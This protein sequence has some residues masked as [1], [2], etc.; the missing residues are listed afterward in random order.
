MKR[1]LYFCLITF[2]LIFLFGYDTKDIVLTDVETTIIKA[3][4]VLR[5]DLNLK[6]VGKQAIESEYDY[7][8][9]DLLGFEV[10]IRP[11]KELQSFMMMDEKSKFKKCCSEVEVEQDFLK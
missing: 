4:K 11:N 2:S 6:N 1:L 7:P 8:G 3:E 9:H 5:Y 10:V